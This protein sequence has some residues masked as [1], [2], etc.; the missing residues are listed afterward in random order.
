MVKSHHVATAGFLFE[1]E[2]ILTYIRYSI[3]LVRLFKLQ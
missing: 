2:R 3:N 1:K